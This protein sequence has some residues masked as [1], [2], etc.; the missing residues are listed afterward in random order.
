M[1]TFD[2]HASPFGHL[3]GLNV[4]LDD[5]TVVARWWAD[6]TIVAASSMDVPEGDAI[7][8]ARNDR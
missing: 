1:T 7:D 2:G 4:S 8:A 6:G 5:A 3:T